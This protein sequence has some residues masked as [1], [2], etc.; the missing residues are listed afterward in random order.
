MST[1]DIGLETLRH[2]ARFAGMPLT[3]AELQALRP[4]VEMLLRSLAELERLPVADVEPTVQYRV[5]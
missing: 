2:A 4:A 5:I 3:D 1:P